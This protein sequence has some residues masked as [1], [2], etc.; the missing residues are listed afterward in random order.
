MGEKRTTCRT[1]VVDHQEN[2]EAGGWIIL[3]WTRERQDG[4]VWTRVMW[5]RIGTSG[6]RP[7]VNPVMNL[8][9]P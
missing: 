1:L 4:V 3:R 9:I 7:L 6:G 8:Q 2:Q 5:L